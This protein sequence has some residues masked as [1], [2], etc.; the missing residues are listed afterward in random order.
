M[1]SRREAI[2]MKMFLKRSTSRLVRG[3]YYQH[4]KFVLTRLSH[5]PCTLF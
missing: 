1:V 4:A 5:K 3:E 2:L